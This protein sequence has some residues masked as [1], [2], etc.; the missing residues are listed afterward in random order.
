MLDDL[1]VGGSLN[2]NTFGDYNE[3]YEMLYIKS[4]L[5]GH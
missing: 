1:V 3:M 5:G 4:V 2:Y